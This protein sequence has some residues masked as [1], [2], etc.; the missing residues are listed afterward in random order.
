[1]K[2]SD[3]KMLTFDT[4]GTLIDWEGGIYNA[5]E[6]L[7][8]KVPVKLHRDEVLELF[9]EFEKKQQAE[10]PSQI[11]SSLLADVARA[12]A[13]K[14]QIKLSDEEAITF[15]K[16]VKHWPAFDDSPAAL[17]YLRRHYLMATVTNCDRIS[18]MGSNARLEIEWDAIYTAQDIGFYKPNLRNFEYM[19]EH[20][21]RQFGV[22]PHEILHVA[23]SLTHDM[24]P[25][26]SM[27]MTKVWINRRHDQ[28][29]LGATAPPEGEY[30]I[31]REFNSM[32]D[33][34]DAHRQEV[35]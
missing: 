13:D 29:G 8:D 12:I 35:G 22:M 21:R 25:A 33:F 6:P 16:S 1:M 26:T 34:V 23:Q 10:N 11:Y 32:A 5:L 28:K 14:W 30:T 19:F 7:L 27:G 9:A 2:L 15:G 3:F 18:Y 4:Y 31:E 24:V 20:A 17:N